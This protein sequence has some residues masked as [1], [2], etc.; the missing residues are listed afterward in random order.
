MRSVFAGGIAL[1]L[2]ACGGPVPDAEE[3]ELV[4]GEDIRLRIAH[5]MMTVDGRTGHAIGI[6]GSAPAPLIRL[7]EGQTVRLHVD[8]VPDFREDCPGARTQGGLGAPAE[9]SAAAGASAIAA[10]AP[11]A[12]TA[13]AAVYS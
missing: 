8:G 12:A 10:T 11:P 7:R 13:A 3:T 5:Q 2:A 1:V 4:S 6:N 9:A